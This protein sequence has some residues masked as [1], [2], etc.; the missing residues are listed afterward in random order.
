MTRRKVRTQIEAVARGARPADLLHE[1]DPPPEGEYIDVD[2]ERL[3][4]PPSGDEHKCPSCGGDTKLRT[5]YSWC[6]SF[7]ACKNPEGGD[8]SHYAHAPRR[9]RR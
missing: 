9:G 8:R 3:H 7:G 4:V 2:G 5:G 6:G 1:W